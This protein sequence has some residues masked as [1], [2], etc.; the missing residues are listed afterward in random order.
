VKS[1]K[2][3]L[4]QIREGIEEELQEKE[5]ILKQLSAAKAET[6]QWKSKFEGEGLI[7]SEELEDERRRRMSKVPIFIFIFTFHEN[8]NLFR[9]SRLVIRYIASFVMIIQYNIGFAAL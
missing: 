8:H 4:E 7:G 6:Q 2:H 3:E 1:I 5:E 9:N